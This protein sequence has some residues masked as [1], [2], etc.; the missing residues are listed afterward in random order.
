MEH[1]NPL[2]KTPLADLKVIQKDLT[3]NSVKIE[4]KL[5]QFWKYYLRITI[6]CIKNDSRILLIY[7]SRITIPKSF[8][9]VKAILFFDLL[10]T[11]L[12]FRYFTLSY[13]ANILF[14]FLKGEKR[15]SKM[16]SSMINRRSTRQNRR[17]LN[18]SCCERALCCVFFSSLYTLHE[19][20]ELPFSFP[21]IL[22]LFKS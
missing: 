14:R 19:S 4:S 20:Q 18:G 16:F 8:D 2:Q 5:A 1:K 17:Q 21:S 13:T 9:L 3:Q 22:F 11:K 12:L 10:K 7:T 15:W 6:H